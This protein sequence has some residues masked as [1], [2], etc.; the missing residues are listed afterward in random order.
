MELAEC[1]PQGVWSSKSRQC[2]MAPLAKAAHRA[3][4]RSPKASTVD[5]GRPPASRTRSM[6]P[7]TA[8]SM[9]LAARMTPRVSRMLFFAASRA[10]GGSWS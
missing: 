9:P 1:C 6:T 8:G 7:W 10:A 5:S 4:T 3:G 2:A